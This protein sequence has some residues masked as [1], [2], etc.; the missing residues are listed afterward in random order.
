MPVGRARVRVAITRFRGAGKEASVT[1]SERLV[2]D[3][4]HEV[5]LLPGAVL[6]ADLAYGALLEALGDRVDPAPK[7][8]ELYVGD[9]PPPGYA[10]DVEVEGVLRAADAAGFERFH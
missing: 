7:E 6:P 10:L 9:E 8:L 2:S 4:H 1:T 5:M 3:R